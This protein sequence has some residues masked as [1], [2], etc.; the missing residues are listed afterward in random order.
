VTERA[1]FL[2]LQRDYF[3]L[4]ISSWYISK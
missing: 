2:F 4:S 3:R 1:F